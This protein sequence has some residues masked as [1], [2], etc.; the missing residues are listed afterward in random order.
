MYKGPLYKLQL[1]FK[2]LKMM[3]IS[4][5]ESTTHYSSCIFKLNIPHYWYASPLTITVTALFYIN[6]P[7]VEEPAR[8]K[9]AAIKR[10][11]PVAGYKVPLISAHTV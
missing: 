8:T 3:G 9:A 6:S 5:D 7:L 10:V 1:I 2:R 4:Q 11:S